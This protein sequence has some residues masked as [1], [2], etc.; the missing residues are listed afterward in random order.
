VALP[1]LTEAERQTITNWNAPRVKGEAE[2]DTLLISDQ[3][4]SVE[5]DET[6]PRTPLEEMLAE[7]WMQILGVEWV[8]I[9]DNFFKIGGHSLLATQLVAHTQDVLGIEIPL[10]LV[11]DAPTIAGFAEAISKDENNREHIERA[12]ELLLS[13]M[14]LSEEEVEARLV[15]EG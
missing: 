2:A 13:V 12:I 11:F 6:E 5:E 3:E 1:T 4:H 14:E 9:H 15:A 7:I 8:G 10:Q